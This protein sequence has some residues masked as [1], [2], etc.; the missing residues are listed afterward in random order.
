MEIMNPKNRH[1]EYEFAA[2]HTPPPTF[3]PMS[4]LP[5]QENEQIKSRPLSLYGSSMLRFFIVVFVSIMIGVSESWQNEQKQRLEAELSYLKAQI[6]PH[7]LFNTL[8]SIY[9]LAIKKSDKAPEAIIQLSAIMRYVISE[10]N[11]VYVSL[12]K[13]I[14]YLSNYI[15]LQKMRLNPSTKVD[16]VVEGIENKHQIAPL[17]FIHYIENA[18]KYG[19][20]T[21]LASTLYF[22]IYISP[23]DVSLWVKNT[24][25]V[26]DKWMYSTKKGL[27]N[28][29]K[30][31]E[32]LYPGNFD[33]KITEDDIFFEVNLK[34]TL[35]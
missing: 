6:N 20:N 34:I 7:F 32:T 18:F 23:Q 4:P 33:L 30:H 2:H 19:V 31:L 22:H 16:F 14:E 35:V 21:E 3:S 1:L 25:F 29:Q 11:Q 9:S 12:E 8:N 24:K 27:K 13:E 15:D 26:K 28:S 5:D 10:S 17:I